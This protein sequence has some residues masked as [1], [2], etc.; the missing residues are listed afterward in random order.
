M[1]QDPVVMEH[2]GCPMSKECSAMSL[3]PGRTFHDPG[4]A[5]GALGRIAGPAFGVD[6][7]PVVRLRLQPGCGAS[8]GRATSNRV[9]HR[10][11]LC[12]PAHVYLKRSLCAMLSAA[13]SAGGSIA[14]QEE[15]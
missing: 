8:P 11:N 12:R 7:G 14:R 3:A 9:A 2:A 13:R 6:H 15:A 4:R 10:S 1:A 5:S